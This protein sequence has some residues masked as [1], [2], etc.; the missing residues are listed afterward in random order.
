SEEDLVFAA[1]DQAFEDK[2]TEPSPTGATD[3][4]GLEP[5]VPTG[6]APRPG[7]VGPARPGPKTPAGVA[8]TLRQ[9]PKEPEPIGE[10]APQVTARF[11]QLKA[12]PAIAGSTSLVGAADAASPYGDDGKLDLT[13]PSG[14]AEGEISESATTLVVAMPLPSAG[15]GGGP[16]GLDEFDP[17]LL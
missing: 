15:A 7:G 1:L 10:G 14:E 9:A 3:A 2:V 13:D 8:S 6:S 16:S 5:F 4:G 17:A 11:G 12:A